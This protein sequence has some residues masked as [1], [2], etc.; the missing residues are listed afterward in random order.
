MFKRFYE[1]PVYTET[2]VLFLNQVFNLCPYGTIHM[3]LWLYKPPPPPPR[4]L[5]LS[6][7]DPSPFETVIAE[8]NRVAWLTSGEGGPAKGGVSS[9]RFW[10]SR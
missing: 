8:V 1:K 4:L 6:P 2:P 5:L 7:R 9:G 10:R 3:L